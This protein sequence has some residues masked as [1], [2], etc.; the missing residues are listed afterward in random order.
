MQTQKTL[1]PMSEWVILA[2]SGTRGHREKMSY[3]LIVQAGAILEQAE[4]FT[5]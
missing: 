3:S 5:K 4:C 2:N 1:R